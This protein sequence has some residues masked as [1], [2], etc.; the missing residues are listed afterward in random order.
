MS[1]PS[2]PTLV[3]AILSL[4]LGLFVL[5]RNKKAS[6]NWTFATWCFLTFYWQACWTLLF[7]VRDEATALLLARLGYSGIIFIPIVFFH[8]VVAFTDDHK[9]RR[10]S[11]LFYSLGVTFMV[12]NWVTDSFVAGIYKY[13]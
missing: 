9:S 1:L 12:L 10:L 11:L 4:F 2:V 5:G 3:T 7:N 6:L 8:F 13:E